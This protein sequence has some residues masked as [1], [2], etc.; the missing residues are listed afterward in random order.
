MFFFFFFSLGEGRGESESL[1]IFRLL[2][3]MFQVNRPFVSCEHSE[4]EN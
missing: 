2:V 4:L 3:N 1:N